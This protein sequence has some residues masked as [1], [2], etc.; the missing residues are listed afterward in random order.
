MAYLKHV[1]K[2]AIAIVAIVPMKLRVIPRVVSVVPSRHRPSLVSG[3]YE[4][5]QRIVFFS[6]LLFSCV[7]VL[8]RR[9]RNTVEI[10][11]LL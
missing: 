7:V 6:P 3:A 9:I 1:T 11:S 5:L 8:W 2:H 10:Y 4:Q